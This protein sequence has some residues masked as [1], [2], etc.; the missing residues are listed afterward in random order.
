MCGATKVRIMLCQQKLLLRIR[1]PLRR[2]RTSST[3]TRSP[4]PSR[5]RLWCA[6]KFRQPDTKLCFRRCPLSRTYHLSVT[7]SPLGLFKEISPKRNFFQR[8]PKAIVIA[9]RVRPLCAFGANS[10]TPALCGCKENFALCGARSKA[11]PLESAS[12]LITSASRKCRLDPNFVPRCAS[13]F[14]VSVTWVGQ[15]VADKAKVGRSCIPTI[16]M[17]ASRQSPRAAAAKK[18]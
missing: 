3:A 7:K 13:K 5:G 1:P 16:G 4:F 10:P 11:L 2:G 9:A 14:Y 15:I 8:D 17:Q 6:S 18:P 12:S